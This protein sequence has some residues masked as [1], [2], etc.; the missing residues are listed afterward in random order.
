[1]RKILSVLLVSLLIFSF[2]ACGSEKNISQG[3]GEES[4]ETSAQESSGK[5][6]FSHEEDISDA[7]Q[8]LGSEDGGK[9]Q[10]A[11]N[12][13]IVYFS[14]WG[15]T[16]YPDDVDATT[17]ASIVPDGDGRY[18]TTEYIANMIADEVGGDLHLIETVMPYTADFD[19]L[20][21]V[22]HGE[23]E[24]NYLPELKES[25][26]DIVGYEVVFVGYPVWATD[27]PQAVLSFLNE[28][29]LSGKTVIP[30]CT[31]DGYGAGHSYQTIADASHAAVSL[32]G[33]AIEAKDVPNAQETVSDWLADIGISGSQEQ[34]TA[35]GETAI[36][37]TIGDITLD[38]VLYD[39]PLAEEIKAYFPLTIS[40]SGYGGREYY[41]GVDFYPENLEGGQKNFENGDITYCEAHHNMA[42]F[43]AQTDH[44]NLSVDV[45]P[46]GRVTSDL[47]VFE[48]FDSREEIT[49]SLAQ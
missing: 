25:N 19:E 42:I 13:L 29:D 10:P 32:D 47:A 33:I 17:S 38:G 37:I 22:N 3:S 30:F 4:T 20:R 14:R 18:G 27:V 26:L 7:Q 34:D 43:Y 45:V 39:T 2:A 24:R 44:P 5:D 41:G 6:D 35:K 8:T 36:Q 15:N 31:H 21:D 11:N 46:I 48:N 16:D 40:M 28:Y 9:D 12:I 1:M 49:F 23:M